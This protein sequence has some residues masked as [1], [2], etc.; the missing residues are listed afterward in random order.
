MTPV[1]P[2]KG[3]SMKKKRYRLFPCLA[4]IRNQSWWRGKAYYEFRSAEECVACI[5]EIFPEEPEWCYEKILAADKQTAE[6]R[7]ACCSWYEVVKGE[8]PM[9][10]YTSF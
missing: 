1:P 9:T 5:K 4:N 2:Q 10:A 3:K 6:G 7:I 8:L